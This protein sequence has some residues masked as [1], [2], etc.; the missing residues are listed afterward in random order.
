VELVLG[1]GHLASFEL[2]L[3][4]VEDLALAGLVDV[5]E[6]LSLVEPFD[7]VPFQADD[8]NHHV[9]PQDL[10]DPEDLVVA[11]FVVDLDPAETFPVVVL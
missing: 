3:D 4:Q 8:S 7:V 2:V 5:V 9:D 1:Q 10:V 6:N 11:P